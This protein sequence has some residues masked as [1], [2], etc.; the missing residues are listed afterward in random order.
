MKKMR[1]KNTTGLFKFRGDLIPIDYFIN[2]GYNWSDVSPRLVEII[3]VLKDENIILPLYKNHNLE[4][5]SYGNK[6]FRVVDYKILTLPQIK[7]FFGVH[8]E[9]IQRVE[10]KFINP[11]CMEAKSFVDGDEE[12]FT[13]PA[14]EQY[15]KLINI[16]YLVD[17]ENLIKFLYGKPENIENIAERKVKDCNVRE[18]LFAVNNKLN[19]D[20]K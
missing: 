16:T 4:I 3:S 13:I 6:G 20:E 17:D 1:S 19:K 12:N 15:D 9:H 14:V 8:G 5:N 10:T 18:L 2:T 7:S 11:F